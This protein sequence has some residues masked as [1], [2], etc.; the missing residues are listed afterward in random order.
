MKR[1]NWTLV[2]LVLIGFVIGTFIGTYFEGSFLNFGQAFGM[3]SPV[4]LNL[5]FI[6]LTFGISFHITISSVIG[7]A[8]ALLIYK[9]LRL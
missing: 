6:T 7:V 5:G 3:S 9:L 8:I 4:V 1:A 2:I